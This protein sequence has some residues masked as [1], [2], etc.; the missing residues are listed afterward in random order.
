MDK[1][2]VVIGAGIAGLT[3]SIKLLKLGYKVTI[4]EKN[5]DVGGLCSGYFVNGFYIDACLHWLMGTNP[6]SSLYKMWE[7]IGAFNEDTKFIRLPSL[8]TIDYK[9]IKVPFYRDLNKTKEAW[10]QISPSDR[11][12]INK[13]INSTSDIA[14]IMSFVLNN[15]K[16]SKKELLG[17][18]KDSPQ[19]A[20]TM[21]QSRED[22]SKTFKNPALKFAIKNAQTGYNN[23]FFFMDVYGLFTTDNADFPSGGAYYMVQRIK[24]K[25]LELG[26]ELLLN[27]PVTRILTEKSRVYA[28]KTAKNVIQADYVISSADPQYTVNSLLSGEYQIKRFKSL[29]SSIDRY[30]P[31]SCFNVYVAVKGDTSFIDVPT[32]ITVKPIKVGHQKTNFMLVRPYHFEKEYFVK[33]DKTVVSLFIDQNHNDYMFYKSLN[34]EDYEIEVKKIVDRM[35]NEF[36]RKY[37]QFKDNVELLSY[38][39]PIDLNKRVNTSYGSIQSYS[40][41]GRGIFYSYNGKIKG[42]DNLYLCGQWCRSIGG[43]PTALITANQIIKYFKKK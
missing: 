25:F 22:Y 30:T 27:T 21:L 34:K 40:L 14:K 37:P 32:G 6:D 15:G 20:K 31:S 3:A 1:K 43:T 11:S 29:D 39:T 38:F 19:L 8:L 7:E 9:G 4:V 26:G 10:L 35:I 28:V 12:S 16:I 33:D 13:F 5:N 42:L 23:I 18:I 24:E 2:V 41:T 17:M 36:I